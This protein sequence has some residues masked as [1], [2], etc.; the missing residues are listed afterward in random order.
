MTVME[1]RVSLITLGV[2]NLQRARTFYESMGWVSGSSPSDD[3]VFF[4]S[5]GSIL[6]LWDRSS[7]A[8]DSGVAD[9]G[10]W[11]GVTLAYNTASEAEVDAV[12]ARGERVPERRSP[13]RR[14]R[15]S[16]AGTR[17]CSS[18]PT[19]ILGRSRTTLG[20]DSTSMVGS[21]CSQLAEGPRGD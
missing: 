1:Q 8:K 15:P 7:L 9:S 16:G 12:I 14:G 6:A 4:E 2:R 20:G 5:R 3:V 13:G 19:V 21:T 18:T 11:G 17:G 10:G